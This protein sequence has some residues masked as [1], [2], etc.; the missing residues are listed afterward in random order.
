MRAHVRIAFLIQ[1]ATSMCYIVTSF[2]ASDSSTFLDN[3]SQTARS[4]GKS[5][6]IQ[7]VLSFSTHFVQNVSHFKKKS[8]RYR[9][10][11][12]N[13]SFKIPVILVGF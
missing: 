11:H 7:N 12:G 2:V 9:Y 8:A 13:F 4:S 1:H 3:T 6:C 5:H 10:R